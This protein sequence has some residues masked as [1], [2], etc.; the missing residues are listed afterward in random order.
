VRASKT[1]YLLIVQT[2]TSV[3]PDELPKGFSELADNHNRG[4]ASSIDHVRFAPR[5]AGGTI[6][7]MKTH[8]LSGLVSLVQCRLPDHLSQTR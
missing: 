7:L 6:L 4:H 8:P 5:A 3:D 2:L 1:S